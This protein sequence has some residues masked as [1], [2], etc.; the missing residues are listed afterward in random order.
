MNT[1]ESS[2]EFID[3]I[4]RVPRLYVSHPDKGH[5]VTGFPVLGGGNGVIML[6]V[7]DMTV[8]LT[9]HPGLWVAEHL[10]VRGTEE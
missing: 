5:L 4:A 2:E 7:G 9:Q 8:R 3:R 1:K 6:L 10:V